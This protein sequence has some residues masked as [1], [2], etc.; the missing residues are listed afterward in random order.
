M[1]GVLLFVPS[2]FCTDT[3]VDQSEEAG[4]LF[5]IRIERKGRFGRETQTLLGDNGEEDARKMEGQLRAELI[6]IEKRAVSFRS[7]AKLPFVRAKYFERNAFTAAKSIVLAQFITHSRPYL[8]VA[9][10][11]SIHLEV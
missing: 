5:P 6:R 8:L 10:E 3:C 11:R 4:A 2:I 1:Q 9:L 7:R